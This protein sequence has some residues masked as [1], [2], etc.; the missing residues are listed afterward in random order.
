MYEVLNGNRTLKFSGKLLAESSSRRVGSLRWVE[1]SL[2]K[3][4][5]GSYILARR[6]VSVVYHGATCSLVTRHNLEEAPISE[7]SDDA[8]ACP[9]CRPTYDLPYVFPEKFRYW[10]QVS[11]NAE[12]VL[13]AL[14]R[15]DEDTNTRYLT[16]VAQNVLEAAADVDP[17][18]DA[19]Y[20]VEYI[21]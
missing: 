18:I 6:G 16:R 3:T 2:Y 1:F 12:P 11:D 8:V 20:R 15:Y 5:S 9:D 10:A 19:I 21:P 7:L 14:Y 17:T 4:D 13:E